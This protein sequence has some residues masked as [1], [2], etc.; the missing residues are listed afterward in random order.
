[1]AVTAFAV[2]AAFLGAVSCEEE[3]SPVEG[4]LEN[5]L[6]SRH[7]LSLTVGGEYTL[8]YKLLPEDAEVKGTAEWTSGDESIATV[9]DGKITAVGAGSTDI[10]L[11]FADKTDLCHVTVSE[12]QVESI[13]LNETDVKLSVGATCQLDA[14]LAPEGI[15]SQ[16]QWTTDDET[17]ATVDENGLVTAIGEGLAVIRAAV[18]DVYA[19]CSVLVDPMQIESVSVEPSSL[20]LKVSEKG[21]LTVTILPVE[22][23][24]S[25]VQ[26][27][28]DNDNVATVANGTVSAI[29]AGDAVITATVGGK[30]ATCTVTVSNIEVESVTLNITEY[31]MK[32]DESLQLEATVSPDN[33]TDR[34]VTWTS[35]D[36]AVATVDKTGKVMA[37][38]PGEVTITA[39]AGTVS[40]TC[41]ITVERDGGS[42]GDTDW[43]V[44][45]LF[46][47]PGY[48]KGIVT[49]VSSTYIKIMHMKIGYTQWATVIENTGVTD[50][51]VAASGKEITERLKTF[52]GSRLDE[53]P[54]LAWCVEQGDNWYMPSKKEAADVLLVA[55]TLN[56]ALEENGGD[57]IDTTSDKF[58]YTYPNGVWACS[59]YG[60]D[61]NNAELAYTDN[62]GASTDYDSKTD[63]HYVI[64]LQQIDF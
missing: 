59:E 3:S 58:T 9:T 20:D 18:G 42:V 55:E 4:G 37:M 26:W 10:I 44:G 35:S 64:V 52:V 39:A 57:L 19:K 32:V 50:P 46:D 7:T 30:S 61:E 51:Q 36:N 22:L 54:A 63:S 40:A 1:M 33:A 47:V 49:E 60:W 14:T 17:V 56:V 34:T 62:Y 12:E 48:D 53:Y 24:D 13:T 38:A 5:V 29:S 15:D 21:E 43:E 28:S 6:L 41:R 16:V 25:Y 27:T 11:A 2:A 45:D 31:T 23:A 8:T